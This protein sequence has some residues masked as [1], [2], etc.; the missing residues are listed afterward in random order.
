MLSL[1][2]AHG[3]TTYTLDMPLSVSA[4]TVTRSAPQTINSWTVFPI[5]N[6]IRIDINN[7]LSGP[8]KFSVSWTSQLIVVFTFGPGPLASIT[9]SGIPATIGNTL[10]VQYQSAGLDPILCVDYLAGCSSSGGGGAGG[11]GGGGGGTCISCLVTPGGINNLL[12][13]MVI[14]SFLFLGAGAVVARR[15]RRT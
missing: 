13:I 3:A 6:T 4:G 5:N 8:W 10:Q 7:L 11:G 9:R 2:P 15:K 14:A 1:T 12:I